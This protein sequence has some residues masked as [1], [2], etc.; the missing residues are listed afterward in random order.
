[1][2]RRPPRSTRTDTLFPYTTLFRSPW[3]RRPCRRAGCRPA[4]GRF[5][6]RRR[7]GRARWGRGRS[8]TRRSRTS[9]W[10]HVCRCSALEHAVA[11]AERTLDPRAEL[12]T[13]SGVAAGGTLDLLA[14][15]SRRLHRAVRI[16]P[17]WELLARRVAGGHGVDEVARMAEQ[18]VE[19]T[20]NV[21]AGDVLQHIGAAEAVVGGLERAGTGLE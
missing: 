14:P 13:N 4:R 16:L 18:L 9:A 7:R 17:V 10:V 21:V 5:R 1:M 19:H 2:I 15:P 3:R 20:G 11:L 8:R 12:P 6:A